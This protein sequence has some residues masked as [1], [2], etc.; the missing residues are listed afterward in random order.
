MCADEYAHCPEAF[1]ICLCAGFAG[2]RLGVDRG[3]PA[4][5]CQRTA[6]R[7]RASR[8]CHSLLRSCHNDRLKSGG[9]A[10]TRSSRRT[11][12]STRTCGRKSSAS[13]AS[14]RCHPS[15]CRGRTTR[16]TKPR[17]PCWKR[18]LDAAA[19][20]SP[21]PWQDRDASAPPR[22]PSTRTRSATFSRWKSMPRRSCRQT[23]PVMASTTSPSAISSPTLLDRLRLRGG[24]DQPR[25][26]R[27][28]QCVSRRR[29]DQDS[30]GPHAGGTYRRPADRH[31]RRRAGSVRVSDGR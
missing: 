22:E 16:P 9:L 14:G 10:L 31:A 26:R 13:F 18:S 27:M 29:D 19:A 2:G 12:A 4:I 20:T 23:N 6:A 11:W 7:R 15:A 5:T 1:H 24:T 25:R 8:A 17:S 30:A 21:K 3:S 28:S